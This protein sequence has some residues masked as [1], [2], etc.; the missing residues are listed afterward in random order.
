MTKSNKDKIELEEL[1]NKLRSLSVNLKRDYEKF[2]LK[3]KKKTNF[4][5]LG[6]ERVYSASKKTSQSHIRFI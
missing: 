3:N 5:F 6:T 4:D 1:S 2:K